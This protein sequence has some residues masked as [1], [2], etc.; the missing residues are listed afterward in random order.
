VGVLVANLHIYVR[1]NS[2][3]NV[4]IN[5]GWGLVLEKIFKI[6]TKIILL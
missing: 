5:L 6:A 4:H 1:H 2:I 3:R